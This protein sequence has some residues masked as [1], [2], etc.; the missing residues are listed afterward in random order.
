MMK[1]LL[2]LPSWIVPVLVLTFVGRLQSEPSK[3]Y[4][5]SGESWQA[6]GGPLPD[7]SYAGYQRGEKPL[8]E[9]APDVSVKD[10]GAVGDGTTDDSAAIQKAI[11]EN[12]GK[13]IALPGGR[14]RLSDV[15]N[16]KSSGTVLQGEGPEKTVIVAPVP[17]QEIHPLPVQYPDTGGTAY[18]YS[19]GFIKVQGST[20]YYSSDARPVTAPAKRGDTVLQLAPGHPFK[21]GDEIVVIASE[22]E[23]LT[24]LQ[25]LY[26]DDPTDLSKAGSDRSFRHVSRVQSVEGASVTLERPLRIDLRPEWK[27]EV[28]TFQPRLEEVGIEHLAFEFPDDPY[29]GHF[30]E[31]GFNAIEINGAAHSWVRDV[32]IRNSD[33]GIS[34][35]G[36]VFCT[37]TGIVLE[38]ERRAENPHDSTGH[39]G[40][41]VNS[42]DCLC[43]DF[44]FETKFIHDLTVAGGSVGSVFSNGRGPDLSL[45]HHKLAPY[46]NLFSNLD[47]GRG[48]RMFMSG[49][50]DAIGRNAGAGN[51]YWNLTSK[52]SVEMPDDFGP[53]RLNFIGVRMRGGSKQDAEGPWI[54]SIR[55]GSVEPP[56]LH[57]AQLAS[58][59]GGGG[60]SN[61]SDGNTMHEWTNTEGKTIPARF[62]GIEGAEVILI[63]DGGREVL[64]PLDKL[65]VESQG[66]ARKLANP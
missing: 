45:D 19:G 9:R 23:G 36:S 13:T 33:S 37:V 44:Q 30:T 51:T 6:T 34:V 49:G 47:L 61:E 41:T 31:K 38:S 53:S 24:L 1:R 16:I 43:T 35:G 56:D 60:E 65:S 2:L 3:I 57:A 64:Y 15:V 8:P 40:I 14:Y 5:K 59:L 63:L 27:A 66:L 58:R 4:G 39:H 55:P 29:L 48:D 50:R 26:R 11:D 17:L 22:T 52:G 12:P 7:F 20:G 28:R 21:A 46:E 18:A 54:E 62:G 32:V 10:Y 42:L 25:Y